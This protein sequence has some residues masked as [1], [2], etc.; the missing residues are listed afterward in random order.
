MPSVPPAPGL[1]STT[2]CWPLVSVSACDSAR[3]RMSLT[4]AGG[5]GTMIL[6]GLAGYVWAVATVARAKSRV[7]KALRSMDPP[8]AGEL[9]RDQG[10]RANE[11]DPVE[12][13]GPGK[14]V[15]RD[16]DGERRGAE[17]QALA[18]PQ[19]PER[20][21]DDGGGADED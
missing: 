16:Q 20:K 1:F 3:A 11:P 2:N 19:R 5:Q 13:R 15:L 9:E 18:S 12:N 10:R 21:S 14:C 8:C 6:T 17:Q 7:A 4:P